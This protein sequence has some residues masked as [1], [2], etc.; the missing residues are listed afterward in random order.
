MVEGFENII[1]GSGNDSFVGNSQNNT[2]DG[3]TGVDT[4]DYSSSSLKIVADLKTATK[5]VT[6]G[7]D[8]DTLVSIEKIIDELLK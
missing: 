6:S 1:G 5:T 4:V 2:L 8:V 7:S 3:G